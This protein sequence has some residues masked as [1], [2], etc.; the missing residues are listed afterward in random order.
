MAWK[1]EDVRI[2]LQSLGDTEERIIALLQPIEGYTVI[3]LLGKKV[4]TYNIE[5]YIVGDTD[6]S[7]IKQ[8]VDDGT[9]VTLSGPDGIVGDFYVHTAKFERQKVIAQTIRTDLEIDDKVYIVNS[10]LYKN[11]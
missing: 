10:E 2:F 6:K 4:P 11:V 9:L 1:L 3:Q 8:Y 7:A 5:Y